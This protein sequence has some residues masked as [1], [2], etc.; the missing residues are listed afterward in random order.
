[1]VLLS[2]VVG[3]GCASPASR[4]TLPLETSLFAIQKAVEAQLPGGRLKSE[5][6]GRE[7]VSRHLAIS[8]SGKWREASDIDSSRFQIS[9]VIL[10]DRRPYTIEVTVNKEESTNKKNSSYRSVGTDPQLAQQFI[11]RVKEQLAKRQGERD[12]IDG[13]RVF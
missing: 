5:G 2:F 12:V 6:A 3:A 9:L 10:G 8:S 1:M 4:A 11:A 13:F 7:F